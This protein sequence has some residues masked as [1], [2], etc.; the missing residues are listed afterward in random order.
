MPRQVVLPV[1]ALL[2]AQLGLGAFMVSASLPLPLV[3]AHSTVAALLLLALLRLDYT[4]Q[5]AS[6]ERRS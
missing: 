4:L 5:P 6:P 2:M 1:L 3:L